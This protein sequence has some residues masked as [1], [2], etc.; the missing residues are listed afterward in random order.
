MPNS[1]S[2]A[3]FLLPG[4]PWRGPFQAQSGIEPGEWQARR[5]AE[6]GEASSL[7]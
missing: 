7:N 2:P 5:K 1:R 4:L 6:E 3:G